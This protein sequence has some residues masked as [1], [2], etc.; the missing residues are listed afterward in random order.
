MTAELTLKTLC[1]EKATSFDR[2]PDFPA[3]RPR[4][5]QN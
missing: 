3:S 2:L 5:L 4:T 1:A